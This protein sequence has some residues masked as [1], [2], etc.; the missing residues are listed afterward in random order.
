MSEK[1]KVR[2]KWFPKICSKKNLSDKKYVR[3]NYVIRKKII[4]EANTMF[5]LI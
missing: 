2:N 4:I 1:N 3:K 5:N